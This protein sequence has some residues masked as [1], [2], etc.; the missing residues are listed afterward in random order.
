EFNVRFGDPETQVVL[1]LLK[2]PLSQ[3]LYHA[4]TG[5]LAEV[6][7]LRWHDGAAVTV[8]LAASGYP[9]AP[10]SGDHIT[11]LDRAEAID[12]V[13]VYHAGTATEADGRLTS[14]GGRV[15]AVTARGANLTEARDTA[16]AALAEIEL[17]G[18]HHRTDIAAKAI[19]GLISAP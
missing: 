11:G 6:E 8:V 13:T 16:Y 2:S 7:P 4:A 9:A 10:R 15:L 12:G 18:G 19:A 1:P 14:S 17:P 3:L 5:T